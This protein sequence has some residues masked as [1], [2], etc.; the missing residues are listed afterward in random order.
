MHIPTRIISIT[1]A[2][3]ALAVAH[4]QTAPASENA[5]PVKLEPLRVTA[6]LWQ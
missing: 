2:L 6:D 5:P 3:T 4:A 1:L